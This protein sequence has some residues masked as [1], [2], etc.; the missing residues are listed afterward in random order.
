MKNAIIINGQEAQHQVD[1]VK[2]MSVG[3]IL[4]NRRS[5]VSRCRDSGRTGMGYFNVD[6]AVRV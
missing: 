3:Q 6:P 5:G 4:R 2:K 1:T